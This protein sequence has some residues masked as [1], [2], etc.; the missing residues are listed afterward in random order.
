MRFSDGLLNNPTGTIVVGGDST[1]HGTINPTPLSNFVI[2]NDSIVTVT[3]DLIFT[4]PFLLTD[5]D[6]DSLAANGSNAATLSIG[7]GQNPG[8]LTVLGNLDLTN[9]VLD[10]NFSGTTAPVIGDI[11]NLIQVNGGVTGT[12][13]NSTVNAGGQIW[14]IDYSDGDIFATFTG[15]DSLPGDFN[16]DGLVDGRDFLAWQRNPN[17]GSL[18]DWQQNYGQGGS[19]GAVTAAVP[20]PGT[21]VL[22]L[23]AAL[24]FA[25]RKR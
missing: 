5:G 13:E 21:I 19:L 8:F 9:A 1:L 24:G 12:F 20:E 18:S 14:E 23:S 3:G 11:V 4:E 10:L 6:E 25:A 15:I 22:L 2:L 16:S 7:I 17:I